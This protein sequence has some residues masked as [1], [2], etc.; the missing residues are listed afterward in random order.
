MM[1]LVAILAAQSTDNQCVVFTGIIDILSSPNSLYRNC[2]FA[3]RAVV[4]FIASH[5]EN[6][7]RYF[8]QSVTV[9]DY[10]LSHALPWAL[11]PAIHGQASPAISGHINQELTLCHS[12]RS[13]IAASEPQ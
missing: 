9:D 13:V 11:Y 7:V 2:V 4:C 1:Y 5:I 3:Y 8:F 12:K 10:H 6:L